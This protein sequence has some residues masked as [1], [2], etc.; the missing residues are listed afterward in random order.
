MAPA[1]ETHIEAELTSHVTENNQTSVAYRCWPCYIEETVTEEEVTKGRGKNKKT[2]LVSNISTKE[3][4]TGK[5]PVLK[6]T[7]M[8]PGEFEFDMALNS[9]AAWLD[10]KG[11]VLPVVPSQIGEGV[12]IAPTS[13][14]SG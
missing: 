10:D 9:M 1:V 11:H 7:A 2:S 8:F 5:G 14:S 4:R 12:V 3:I 6:G 13:V